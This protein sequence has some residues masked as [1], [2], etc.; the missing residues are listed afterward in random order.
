V[1]QSQHPPCLAKTKRPS[2]IRQRTS[3]LGAPAN[4]GTTRG[5]HRRCAWRSDLAACRSDS[6][7]RGG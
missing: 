2:F 7:A 5:A 3:A 1:A 6:S 4:R